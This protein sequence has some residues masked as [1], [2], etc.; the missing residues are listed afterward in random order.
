MQMMRI[1]ELS[2]LAVLYVG[3]VGWA[4][5]LKEPALAMLTI[6][7]IFPLCILHLVRRNLTLLQKIRAAGW[8]PYLIVIPLFFIWITQFPGRIPF[9]FIAALSGLIYFISFGALMRLF[10]VNRS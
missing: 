10:W 7:T 8:L 6:L 1:G 5:L 3:L 9:F 4:I 2:V